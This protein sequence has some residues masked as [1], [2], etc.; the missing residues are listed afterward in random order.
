[1]E[2]ILDRRSVRIFSDL[3]PGTILA[4]SFGWPRVSAT[5]RTGPRQG[6]QGLD[7][8]RSTRKKDAARQPGTIRRS[9]SGVLKRQVP[10]SPSSRAQALGRRG[11]A[12]ASKRCRER[13]EARVFVVEALGSRSRSNASGLRSAPCR[14]AVRRRVSQPLANRP[15]PLTRRAAAH[16]QPGMDSER[17]RGQAP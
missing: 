12:Q 7:R 14:K 6:C 4:A 3:S 9:G 16:L 1:M 13:H 10:R 15:D 5:G 11:E 2:G 17:R 8:S